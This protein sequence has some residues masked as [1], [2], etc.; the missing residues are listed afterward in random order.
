MTIIKKVKK[1][2]FY[3]CGYKYLGDLLVGGDEVVVADVDEVQTGA[4]RHCPTIQVAGP[5]W[6]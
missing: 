1:I 3:I 2:V 5:S 4:Y 6:V